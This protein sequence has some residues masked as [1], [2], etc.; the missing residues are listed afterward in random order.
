[1]FKLRNTHTRALHHDILQARFHF[2]QELDAVHVIVYFGCL[3]VNKLFYQLPN[4]QPTPLLN[5]HV[6]S[7]KNSDS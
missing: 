6:T 1:M 5:L 4:P 3:F 2:A 7:I